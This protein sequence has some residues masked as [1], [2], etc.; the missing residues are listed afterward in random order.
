VEGCSA[1]A[2]QW[3]HRE[4]W[5]HTH[6]TPFDGM[7]GYCCHHHDKKTYEGWGLVEGVGKR[8]FVS[9]E[10]PRHPRHEKK[11]RPPPERAARMR[12]GT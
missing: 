10:D 11:E 12:I 9:P 3:D 2:A 8:T 5:A 7:D 6:R 1:S 4:D